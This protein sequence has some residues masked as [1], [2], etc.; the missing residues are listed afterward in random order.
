MT[1]RFRMSSI[2]CVIR[3]EQL[4]LFALEF[5]KNLIF[6]FVYTV[7]S[8]NINHLIPDLVR[9]YMT[10]RPR[11]SSILGIIRPEQQQ[12]H[13]LNVACEAKG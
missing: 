12:K 2:M 4:E 3:P 8:T 1:I 7:A 6:H 11:M 9:I 13:K 5:K 10:L